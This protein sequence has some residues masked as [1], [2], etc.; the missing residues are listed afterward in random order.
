MTDD[1]GRTM[2][3]IVVLGSLHMDVLVNAPDRPRKGETLRGTHWALR[4]GGKG[5][6]QA[7]QAAQQGAEVYMVG[8]VGNDDFGPKLIAALRTAGVNTEYVRIE[9]TAGSGMSVAIVD[10][11]GDY[12]AIIVSGVNLHIDQADI[13]RASAILARADCL[14]LQYEIPL[15]TVAAAARFAHE[16]GVR[17]M[18]NAAPA[19]P[20]PP[21]LLQFVD[22]LVVNEVEAEML[23]G[24][25]VGNL[26]QARHVA[27]LLSHQVPTA[28]LTLGADGVYIADRSFG[29]MHVP[30]Y[31]VEIVDT[32]GAGDSF[33]GALGV[34]L[35]SGDSLLESVRYANATGALTVMHAGPQSNE[36]TPA[37]VRELMTLGKT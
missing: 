5:G 3:R 11:H 4:A 16:H 35:G 14:I 10:E 33:I 34:R 30:G 1:G 9:D 20:A 6:N 23:A 13:E 28:V 8:R 15:T 32:H 12:G 36:V 17:V 19:Y 21:D 18:L 22:V 37:R 26:D 24:H 2:P 25:P 7:V 29:C 27:E 31:Q